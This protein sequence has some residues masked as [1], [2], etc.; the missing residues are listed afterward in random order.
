MK[1]RAFILATSSLVISSGL[2]SFIFDSIKFKKVP[3]KFNF[4]HLEDSDVKVL[5]SIFPLILEGSYKTLNVEDYQWLLDDWNSSLS[6]AMENDYDELKELLSILHSSWIERLALK[7]P[8]DYT[9]EK[10]INDFLEYWKKSHNHFL[11]KNKLIAAYKTLTNI[12]TSSWYSK[13]DNFELTGYEG[14]LALGD[15]S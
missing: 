10:Q 3:A 11:A 2:L 9:N 13:A 7:V 15:Q 1:R 8:S 4:S 6:S 12:T 14:P 5:V